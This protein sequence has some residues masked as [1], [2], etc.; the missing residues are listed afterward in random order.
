MYGAAVAV[1]TASNPVQVIVGPPG[2]LVMPPD[3]VVNESVPVHVG[4]LS[5]DTGVG[6]AGGA[7]PNLDSQLV[8]S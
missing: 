7:S 3:N 2:G 1:K 8:A 4:R 6:P 5:A